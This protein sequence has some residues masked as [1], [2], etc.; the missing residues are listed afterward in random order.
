MF[1]RWKLFL[2]VVFWVRIGS[3]IFY[4]VHT[5]ND[6]L[7][8]WMNIEQYCFRKSVLWEKETG[9]M[10]GLLWVGQWFWWSTLKLTGWDGSYIFYNRKIMKRFVWEKNLL[11]NFKCLQLNCWWT[12]MRERQLWHWK[13]TV[14]T[15]RII[16][17]V[18][19]ADW[20]LF[21]ILHS[22]LTLNALNWEWGEIETGRPKKDER[23]KRIANRW[24][25]SKGG[26]KH[27]S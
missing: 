7:K 15:G 26:G 6:Q 11:Q 20:S 16:C 18:W 12:V 5:R 13:T 10:R 9:L 21:M 14:I 27:A 25:I 24:L 19:D 4:S 1:M 8:W 22:F 2:E 17:H 23:Q 3:N